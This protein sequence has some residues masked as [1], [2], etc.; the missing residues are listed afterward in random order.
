[1]IARRML[2]RDPVQEEFL[3]YAKD[4]APAD[5][6]QGTGNH[7]VRAAIPGRIIGIGNSTRDQVAPD[8]GKVN[9]PTPIVSPGNKR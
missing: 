2:G 1:M 9:L 4:H 3:R 7:E 6:N 8:V 5:A